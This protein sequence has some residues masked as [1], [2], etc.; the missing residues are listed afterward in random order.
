MYFLMT[1]ERDIM[2]APHYF[3][4][5]WKD[6][7]TN[8]L[9]NEVEGRCHGSIGWIVMVVTI[10]NIGEGTVMEGT[11]YTLF[12]IIFEAIVFRPYVKEVLDAIVMSV[13]K[14]GVLVEAG[15]ML[16]WI[17]KMKIPSNYQYDDTDEACWISDGTNGDERKIFKSSSV[18]VSVYGIR[19][20]VNNMF[21][22][23]AIV[24]YGSKSKQLENTS[25]QTTAMKRKTTENTDNMNGNSN[26]NFNSNSNSN[27][28][29]KRLRT[30]GMEVDNG[31][32]DD[33][34]DNH[35]YDYANE[36]EIENENYN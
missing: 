4:R 8:Q 10:A 26:S 32:N 34:D 6:T 5:N 28:N 3:D 2:L 29:S 20:E 24:D 35:D 1:L 15:P 33:E 14:D 30:N 19:E 9:R 31:N 23:G 12:P 21:G 18:R 17:S 22:I 7:L 13:T 27:S 11:S 16:L 25:R 36:N